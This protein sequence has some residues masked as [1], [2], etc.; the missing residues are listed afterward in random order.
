MKRPIENARAVW[1][2]A[3]KKKEA[4]TT[5]RLVQTWRTWCAHRWPALRWRPEWFTSDVTPSNFML[6][7]S[8]PALAEKERRL[9]SER[10]KAAL[11]AKR[12]SG[13]RLGNLRNIAQAGELGR[14][15]QNATADKFV[16]NLMPVVQAI[17][18]TG[19]TTLEAITQALNQRGI[20]TARG[21]KWSASSVMNVL[22]RDKTF[23]EASALYRRE[24][25]HEGMPAGL[26]SHVD[27]YQSPEWSRLVRDDH[28]RLRW[29]P[30]DRGWPGTIGWLRSSA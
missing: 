14:S 9:I 1:M 29:R 17:Q 23:R 20:R 19:A 26:R 3:A 11:A 7:L 12:A 22:E 21:T 8:Y 15:V 30:V 18:N 16:A 5:T 25:W 10:T 27:S 2:P 6:H 24:N 13:V 28:N 4:V